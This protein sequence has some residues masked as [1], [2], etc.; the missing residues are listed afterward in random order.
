[1]ITKLFAAGLL[2]ALAGC[3]SS[4]PKN[5]SRLQGATAEYAMP[6]KQ[7]LQT[8]K[9]VIAAPPMSLGVEDEHK[10]TILT[11]WQDF[12]GEWHVARR[13]QEHT[14]YRIIITPDFDDPTGHSHIEVR[15]ETQQRATSGQ[16]WESIEELPR[17]E[18]SAAL[19]K[20]IEQQVS[21]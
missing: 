15:E 14:R 18:R 1:M 11:T 5:D 4:F 12:P 7:L 10:G 9:Q 3:A 8:V 19:L 2:I 13:W 6:P 20:Q 21:K 16:K 17:P